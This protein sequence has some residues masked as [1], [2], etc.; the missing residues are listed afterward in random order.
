ML[1]GRSGGATAAGGWRSQ[2]TLVSGAGEKSWSGSGSYMGQAIG[3]GID[4]LADLLASRYA[5]Q[6]GG[7][8][9]SY[10]LAI[11][12][13]NSLSD[14]DRSMRY[15][16]RI[17]LISAFRLHSISQDQVIYLID[18]RGDIEGLERALRLERRLQPDPSSRPL[19]PA[20][21]IPTVTVQDKTV[22]DQGSAPMTLYYRLR[23]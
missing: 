3:A 1:V 21:A 8:I 4:G 7:T 12:N 2:W 22:V 10:K 19:T 13:V 20:T 14:Y 16:G 18:L 5:V 23:P 11:N 9:S 17:S 6:G 15:L